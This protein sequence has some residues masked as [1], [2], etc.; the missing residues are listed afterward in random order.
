V[1]R[2]TTRECR[3][4]DLA[5]EGA[6]LR[7]GARGPPHR[8]RARAAASRS[9]PARAPGAA[10]RGSLAR[11]AGPAARGPAGA[12]QPP[13]CSAPR[14]TGRPRRG[15]VGASVRRRGRTCGPGQPDPDPARGGTRRPRSASSPWQ[16]AG[17]VSRCVDRAD[18]A[19]P[20]HARTSLC[21]SP[22]E[23]SGGWWGRLGPV[24]FW[25]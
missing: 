14:R 15:R 23:P 11:P 1:N 8:R 22:L 20:G 18:G 9:A 7:V 2:T 6:Y 17:G 10:A 16:A 12:A 4:G 21:L 13:P 5:K 3:S 19:R 25:F 24:G